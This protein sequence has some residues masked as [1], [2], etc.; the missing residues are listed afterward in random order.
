[1]F[2]IPQKWDS[3]KHTLALEVHPLVPVEQ[4]K[5]SIDMQIQSLVVAGPTDPKVW[6]VSKSYARFFP[7]VEPPKD[8]AER[9][10][11]ARE[12]L[13]AF[14][15]KAFRRPAD[16]ATVDR[17]VKIAE[18]GWSAPGKQFEQGIG[19]AMI[20]TLSSPRFLFRVEQTVKSKPDELYSQIDEYSLASRL[21]YF[22]WSTMPDDELMGLAARGELRKNYAA[23]VKRLLG[24]ERA[25]AMVRNFTG[26]WLQLRD[27]ES[28]AIDARMVRARDNNTEKEL[29]AQIA[30][31]RARQFGQNNQQ[32]NANGNNPAIPNAANG[33][34][35]TAVAP[36]GPAEANKGA[37][38]A[39]PTPPAANGTNPAP[40]VANANGQPR[41]RA[42]AAH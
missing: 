31:F 34:A 4:R 17:L 28:I 21:S 7:R 38:G 13:S 6:N 23:Q 12:V 18:T 19:E 2:E 1:V 30:A 10:E 35:G 15:T 42:D 40:A 37:T 11:Y 24:D 3:G 27:V 16:A 33:N 36:K 39:A 5:T 41:P 26:Q 9:R 22:L 25:I 8:A 20:A 14:T 29:A 32:P